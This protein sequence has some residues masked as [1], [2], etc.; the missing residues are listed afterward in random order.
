MSN[1]DAA[2]KVPA[3]IRRIA[4][5]LDW[6]NAD[7]RTLLTVVVGGV[8]GGILYRILGGDVGDWPGAA[9]YFV[10]S[11]GGAC[12]AGIGVFVLA[13]SARNDHLR[14]LFFSVVCGFSYPAVLEAAKTAAPTAAEKQVEAASDALKRDTVSGA[15]TLAVAIEQNPALETPPDAGRELAQ[16]ATTAI[17]SIG[18]ETPKEDGI[19]ALRSIG[20][21][22]AKAGYVTQAQRAAERLG[23][24]KTPDAMSA[25]AEIEAALV[26]R[27]MPPPTPAN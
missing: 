13:N 26:G 6:M 5:F 21:A 3:P 16:V 22:S 10:A 27:E 24:L 18:Q 25:K 11:F 9:G 14:I 12:A 7:F 23:G 4:A 20:V 19:D 2:A 8:V 17:D 1:E 15:K